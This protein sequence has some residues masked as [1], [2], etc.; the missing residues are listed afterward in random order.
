[1][2]QWLNNVLVNIIL[3]LLNPLFYWILFTLLLTSHFRVKKERKQ[4]GKKIKGYFSEVKNT[5]LLTLCFGVIISIITI[6]FDIVFTRE[7]VLVLMTVT[8]LLTIIRSFSF[9]SAV[10]TIGFTYIVLLLLPFVLSDLSLVESM[11]FLQEESFIHLVILL[12]IFLLA[13]TTLVLIPKK[14]TTFPSLQKSSRGKWIGALNIKRALVLPFLIY[15]PTEWLESMFPFIAFSNSEYQL[16]LFPFMIG[17]QMNVQSILPLYIRMALSKWLLGL[18]II[19]IILANF[20]FQMPILSVIA[21]FIAIIGR[22]I[23]I[24]HIR[25]QDKRQRPM[26]NP[27]RDGLKVLAILPN[28]PANRIGLTIGE[29]I[30]KVNGIDVRTPQQFYEALQNSGAFFKLYIR[31]TNQEMRFITSAF[32]EEDHYELGIIFSKDPYGW[33][34][35]S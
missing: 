20:A 13:E 10:Y 3:L 34:E 21:V 19:L 12:T 30:T 31:D 4:F 33:K 25:L 35:N 9:L 15:I 7:I 29:T 24:L 23:I 2:D 5:I 17:F 27:V 18:T 14:Q 28:S 26:F 32:Y 16:I 22:E 11:K 8:I 1:M 6:M